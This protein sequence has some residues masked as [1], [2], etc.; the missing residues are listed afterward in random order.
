MSRVG[1]N[2]DSPFQP[3]RPN[4]L[5]ARYLRQQAEA[6]KAGL[7]GSE[8]GEVTLYDSGPV[9]PVDAQVAWREALTAAALLAPELDDWQPPSDW[10]RL[11]ARHEPVFDLPLSLG[12]FPQ[13][14]RQLQPLLTAP[15]LGE[16]L[17]KSIESNDET[18]PPAW[19]LRAGESGN[20]EAMLI[21]A[22]ALRLARQFRHASELLARIADTGDPALRPLIEN[23]R[24]AIAWHRGDREEAYAM[25][26]RLPDGPVAWFN[27]GMAALFLGRK[28]EARA[29]LQHAIAMLDDNTAWYHLACLYRT[30]ADR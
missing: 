1:Q 2:T 27:R 16:L 22:A 14:V 9:H 3:P 25:W 11:V 23:E 30:L 4:E 7:T 19:V 13:L 6:E 8:S 18:E 17:P 26:Q 29:A 21:A 12:N 20:A 24:A 15:E 10:P 28:D 5:L